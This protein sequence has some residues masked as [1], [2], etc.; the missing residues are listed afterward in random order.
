MKQSCQNVQISTWVP[1]SKVE[2]SAKATCQGPN[3]I[4]HGP[5]FG[6]GSFYIWL[7]VLIVTLFCCGLCFGC[8]KNNQRKR[9]AREQRAV[10]MSNRARR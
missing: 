8:Y 6:A 10:E 4:E 1:G 3:E 9:L 2:A 5:D 7:P